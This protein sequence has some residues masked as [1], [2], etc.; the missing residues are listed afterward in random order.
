VGHSDVAHGY[1]ML[2]SIWA[3][4]FHEGVDDGDG[5]RHLALV[6]TLKGFLLSRGI[7]VGVVACHAET[8]WLVE[9]AKV[10]H[11]GRRRYRHHHRRLHRL[12]CP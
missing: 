1:A 6:A 3:V 12:P 4:V 2:A 11:V 8:S 5:K 10:K 7:V 9:K